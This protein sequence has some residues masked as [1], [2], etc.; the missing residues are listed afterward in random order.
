MIKYSSIIVLV[1]SFTTGCVNKH[2]PISPSKQAQKYSQQKFSNNTNRSAQQSL[3]WSGIYK[4]NVPCEDC[5]VTNLLLELKSEGQYSLSRSYID[6][7]SAA[8]M[9]E[10]EIIWSEVGNA[11]QVGE[12]RFTVEEHKLSLLDHDGS[13]KVDIEGNPYVLAKEIETVNNSL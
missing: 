7:M 2:M 12:Y 1:L 3:D 8:V 4:G 10:G 9:E 6:K 11:I 5:A 13:L